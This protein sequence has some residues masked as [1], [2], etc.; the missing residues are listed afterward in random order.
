M[1][2]PENET[3][4]QEGDLERDREREINGIYNQKAKLLKMCR[5]YDLYRIF[6]TNGLWI[7]FHEYEYEFDTT[8]SHMQFNLVNQMKN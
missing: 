6:W 2:N 4:E 7:C 3:Y 1:V 5:H 8:E